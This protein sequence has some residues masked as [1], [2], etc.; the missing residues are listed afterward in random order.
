[1]IVR[2]SMQYQGLLSQLH[3][4]FLDSRNPAQSFVSS[5]IVSVY[6]YTARVSDGILMKNW[7]ETTKFLITAHDILVDDSRFIS[8]DRCYKT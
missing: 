6:I 8:L 4:L 5:D 3:I 2:A 7:K 1:M